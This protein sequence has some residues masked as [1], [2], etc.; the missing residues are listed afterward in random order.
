MRN[1]FP[2]FANNTLQKPDPARK[3]GKED[4]FGR[5]MARQNA[6]GGGAMQARG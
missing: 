2:G 6:G 5:V 3:R 1:R 4:A